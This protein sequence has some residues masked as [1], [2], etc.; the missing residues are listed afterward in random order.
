MIDHKLQET[1]DRSEQHYSEFMESMDEI[2][3]MCSE[4]L[5]KETGYIVSYHIDNNCPIF[6]IC[7]VDEKEKQ[8][9]SKTACRVLGSIAEWGTTLPIVRVWAK[10]RSLKCMPDMMKLESK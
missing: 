9:L 10:D 3:K 4:R 2:G 1:I 5:Q 6:T 8:V 7:D